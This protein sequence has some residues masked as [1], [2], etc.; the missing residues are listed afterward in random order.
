MDSTRVRTRLHSRTVIDLDGPRTVDNA[1]CWIWTGTLSRNSKDP[2]AGGYGQFS[3]GKAKGILAH[4][5]AYELAY[6]PIPAGLTIDHLCHDP[7]TCQPPCTHRACV[8]PAHL[9]AVPG[10]ANTL[11]GG[12]PSALNAAKTECD[13]G[14]EFTEANTLW[15]GAT[16]RRHRECRTCNRDKARRYS[17]AER[18]AEDP[19]APC[20]NGHLRTPENTYIIPVNG[21]RQ[22][23]DCKSEDALR[24]WSEGTFRPAS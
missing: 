24:R 20:K 17:A 8:N 5:A 9:N 12:G 14:H 19:D 7:E 11:R 16:S 10:R 3:V 13:S 23:R 4:R 1:P 21:S 2:K 22:C 15:T 6:G 18:A